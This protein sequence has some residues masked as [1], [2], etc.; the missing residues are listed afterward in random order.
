MYY[1]ERGAKG[2]CIASEFVKAGDVVDVGEELTF[3]N[4][5]VFCIT[6]NV[7]AVQWFLW[8]PLFPK[9]VPFLFLHLNPHQKLTALRLLIRNT[10]R[11]KEVH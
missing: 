5:G 7:H 1:I 4:W 3:D 6:I 8:T 11:Q 10:F 9:I 2:A